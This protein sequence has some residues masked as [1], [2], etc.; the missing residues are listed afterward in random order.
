MHSDGRARRWAGLVMLG[1][2]LLAGSVIG[3]IAYNAGVAHGIAISA[4]AGEIERGARVAVHPY[5]YGYGWH[6]WGF[7]FGFLGPLLFV[8]FWFF[9]VRML[10]WWRAPWRHYGYWHRGYGYGPPWRGP[11]GFRGPGRWD[12]DDPD[13]DD[14]T[15]RRDML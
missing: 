2:M 11:R 10:F 12:R 9:V 8:A 13:D 15:R 3:Y 5:G 6:P 14:R 1:L 7:G 4:S